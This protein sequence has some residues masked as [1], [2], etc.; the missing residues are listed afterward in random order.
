MGGTV[1]VGAGIV[2]IYCKILL[3]PAKVAGKMFSMMFRRTFRGA[4]R[5]L[6]CGA[7]GIAALIALSA[8]SNSMRS[9]LKK[10]GG[11]I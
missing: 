2:G 4:K 6:T 8:S 7:L 9:A 1:T 11:T 3:L 5:R 10:N